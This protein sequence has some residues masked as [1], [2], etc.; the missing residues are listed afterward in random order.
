MHR[1]LPACIL[2]ILALLMALLAPGP[3]Q[4]AALARV[5]RSQAPVTLVGNSAIRHHSRCDA[6]PRGIG[7]RL[8]EALGQPVVDLSDGGQTLEQGAN[9]AA[10]ALRARP[11]GTLVV[12]LSL[13]DFADWDVLPLQ[14][15]LAWRTLNPALPAPPLTDRLRAGRLLQGLEPATRAAFTHRGEAYPGYESVK[16]RWFAA[17][18]RAMRCPETDGQDLRFI[19]A[20]HAFQYA[21]LPV[22]AE[23]LALLRALARQARD[24]GTR[25]LWVLMPVDLPLMAAMDPTLADAV[26]AR[27]Q[28]LRERLAEADFAV[29]D[30]SDAVPR[31][32][33]AD[34]WC[35]CGHLLEAGR[36]TV[37]QRIAQA[38]SRLA[39]PT[40]LTD[41]PRS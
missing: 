4:L 32:A 20:F 30:L 27:L 7:E 2:A 12:P 21:Q 22:H 39:A 38:L 10:V 3:A 29:L 23:A 19:E 36:Q 37:A 25:T 34:R 1:H 9:L 15:T 41:E 8:G 28:T 6:D 33:F 5:V 26:R 35:A 18:Q 31:E 13:F 14:E 40:G 17:E 16:T 24:R 11:G